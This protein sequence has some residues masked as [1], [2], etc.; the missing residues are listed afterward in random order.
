MT[1]FRDDVDFFCP[2]GILVRFLFLLRDCRHY[3]L[4]SIPFYFVLWIIIFIH[5]TWNLNYETSIKII[6]LLYLVISSTF[7]FSSALHLWIIFTL[8]Y[9]LPFIDVLTIIQI[10]VCFHC[11]PCAAEGTA[12]QQWPEPWG[13]PTLN[14]RSKP[15]HA[16]SN[17]MY[18]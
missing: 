2:D 18:F 16:S 17:G 3:I 12:M 8:H 15:W 13:R 7:D 9:S 6:I 5:V 10:C 4:L 11:W 14:I 1:T